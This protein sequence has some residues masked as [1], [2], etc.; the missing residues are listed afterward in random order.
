MQAVDFSSNAN[1]KSMTGTYK[2]EAYKLVK[3]KN[4]TFE[5]Y[6]TFAKD[7]ADPIRVFNSM[8]H[9]AEEKVQELKDKRQIFLNIDKTVTEKYKE[10][11]QA[12]KAIPQAAK[13]I[14]HATKSIPQTV[15]NQTKTS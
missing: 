1:V 2:K 10:S 5:D 7:I 14:P 12:A 4:L 15:K 8:I 11:A 9:A 13:A 6:E 3:R